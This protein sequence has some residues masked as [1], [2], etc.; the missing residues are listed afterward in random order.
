MCL[1][2]CT[3]PLHATELWLLRS[4][5]P[6]QVEAN[7]ALACCAAAA[8]RPA[9]RQWRCSV[10]LRSRLRIPEQEPR[11]REAVIVSG[12]RPP[13][14]VSLHRW[15]SG[16]CS[17]AESWAVAPSESMQ[18]RTREAMV[19]SGSLASVAGSSQRLASGLALLVGVLERKS[20]S[21]RPRGA[22][23]LAGGRFPEAQDRWRRMRGR[24]RVGWRSAHVPRGPRARP[25]PWL[26]RGAG[27]LAGGRPIES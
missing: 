13:P 17:M 21:C 6:D 27:S 19:V 26:L 15:A 16:L 25:W 9:S 5:H 4:V 3:S 18:P 1:V 14:A 8:G 10:G 23:S 7:R 22:C 20:R 12:S 11:M 2:R 24:C